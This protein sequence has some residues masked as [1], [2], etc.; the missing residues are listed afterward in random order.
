[1]LRFETDILE[2]L[3]HEIVRDHQKHCNSHNSMGS[4]RYQLVNL[5]NLGN[6]NGITSKDA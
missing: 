4:L 5:P 1:M 3:M 6:I 2:T